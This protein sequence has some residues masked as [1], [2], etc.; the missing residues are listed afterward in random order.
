MR[1]ART[2]P[3]V[4]SLVLAAALLGAGCSK[5]EG[6]ATIGSKSDGDK[7]VGAPGPSATHGVDDVN[8]RPKLGGAAGAGGNPAECDGCVPPAPS[9]SAAL[10]VAKTLPAPE[11]VAAPPK[12]AKKTASGLASKVLAKGTGKDHPNP[13]DK[14]K[15]HYTGW[16]KDGKMFD[17]SVVR[18][19]PTEFPLSGVIKGW[20]EG[21]QQM[22]VGEKRRFWIPGALAYGDKPSMPGTP[23]GDLTF[24]IEL[25]EITKGVKPPPTPPDV[26][27]PPATSKKT[28]SGLHY[29]VIKAGTGKTSPA[30]TSKVQVNYTGW[31]TDGKM[32]DSSTT[33]GKPASFP[34]NRVIKGWTEGVQLMK[35][36]DVYRFWIPGNLAY[37]DKPARPGAPTGMLVFDIELVDFN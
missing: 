19:E 35:K 13:E 7:I 14:V 10:P 15:V 33:E 37:G 16:S 32:F 8:V 27:A 22:V 2:L 31:T 29:R 30:A 4:A 23:S 12:D 20:T 11:D 5:P 36:G 9:A 21:V 1:L 28:A 34:L 17:S 24:D 6:A 26:K 3:V 18:G 25:L